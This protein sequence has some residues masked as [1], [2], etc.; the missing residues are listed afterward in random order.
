MRPSSPPRCWSRPSPPHARL[1]LVEAA[2]LGVRDRPRRLPVRSASPGQRRGRAHRARRRT[3]SYMARRSTGCTG[4]TSSRMSAPRPPRRWTAAW[5]TRI[6]YP[7]LAAIFTAVVPHGVH[8]RLRRRADR[9]DGRTRRR[10]DRALA[11]PAGPVAFGRDRDHARFRAAAVLRS[12]R[13]P[14]HHRRRVPGPVAVRWASIGRGRPPG[15]PGRSSAPSALAPR[16]RPSSLPGSWFP[17]LL[18]GLWSVRRSELPARHGHQGGRGASSASPS[19]SSRRSTCPS[20][21]P[22]RGHGSRPSSRRSSRTPCPM[23]R[24][25]SASRITCSMAVASSP[26]TATRTLQLRA[27]GAGAVR[28]VRAP[29][30]ACHVRPALDHLL[31]GHPIPGWLLP[32]DDAALAGVAR[33]RQPRTP[34]R[35]PGNRELA[36][37][38]DR[39]VRIALVPL[40]LLPAVACLGIAIASA[41]PLRMQVT[42]TTMTAGRGRITEIEVPRHQRRRSLR[43][44]HTSRSAVGSRCLTVLAPGR[45]S[46]EPRARAD[47]LTTAS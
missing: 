20:W 21:Q 9:D 36:G 15:S 16:A 34:S 39:R 6:P 19:R 28:P 4:R 40:L 5:S 47:A 1:T 7:P 37:W 12:S 26:S 11:A 30:R 31:P 8:R 45:R 25:W 43:S 41:P 17:F 33:D 22:T 32:A 42:S 13:L 27:R 10:R 38:A 3:R 24:G 18:V 2:I 46:R 35:P 44:G 23:G 29:A 14:S